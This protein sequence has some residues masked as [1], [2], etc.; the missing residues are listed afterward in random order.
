MYAYS[1]LRSQVRGEIK[2]RKLILF[3]VILIGI[4]YLFISFIFGE[5]GI[6]KYI[7]ISAKKSNLEKEIVSLQKENEQLR[8]DMKVIKEEPFY[9]EKYAREEYGLVK[10]GD[11]VFITKGK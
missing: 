2:K 4:A 7:E 6:I 8:R 11:W 10:E 5:Q 9:I 3:T 1:P